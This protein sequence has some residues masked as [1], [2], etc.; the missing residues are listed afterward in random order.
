MRG[1]LF[2]SVFLFSL[3]GCGDEEIVPE[4]DNLIDEE[5]YVKLIVE[6]Q[7][8]DAWVFTSEEISNPDSIKLEL[9][10][11]Y[12]TTEEL[13]DLSNTFYQSK[14]EGHVARIDSAKKILE[15]E[16]R[17]NHSPLKEPLFD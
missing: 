6:L 3:F 8:L 5:T 1:F 14:P 15:D 12:N 7:L 9:F 10:K 4:P 11:Y 13:F 17:L 16:L 2:V